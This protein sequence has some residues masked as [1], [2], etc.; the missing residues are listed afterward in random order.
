M[1]DDLK[2]IDKF[3]E[4]HKPE[5]MPVLSGNSLMQIAIQKNYAPEFIE[6]MMALQERQ[7]KNEAK[8]AFHVSMAR[9]KANP[10]KIFR[11]MQVKYTVGGKPTKWSHADLATAAE[12]INK[13]LG[14]NGL[15][16][17]AKTKYRPWDQQFS[18]LKDILYLH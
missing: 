8:K 12:A 11:D 1:A 10:P 5:S 17:K 3:K 14:E 13:S 18:I 16:S 7:E 9:F 15:N 4:R 2:D 6:K